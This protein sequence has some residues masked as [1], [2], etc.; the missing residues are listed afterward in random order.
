MLHHGCPRLRFPGDEEEPTVVVRAT[1]AVAEGR[2][3]LGFST[4]RCSAGAGE[5]FP[6]CDFV[7]LEQK[8]KVVMI[9]N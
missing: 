4:Q 1:S 5:L 6:M 3:L 7:A 2:M 8:Q 9:V